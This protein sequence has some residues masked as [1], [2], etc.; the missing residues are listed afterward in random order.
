MSILIELLAV[1]QRMFFH[2]GYPVPSTMAINSGDFKLCGEV[3]IMSVLQGG[4]A[5]NCLAPPVAC[6][7]VG[8]PLSPSEI[9]KSVYKSACENVSMVYTVYT[10]HLKLA[11]NLVLLIYHLNG[12]CSCLM[13]LLCCNVPIFPLSEYQRIH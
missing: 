6:F 7:I 12:L 11:D 4:P 13:M 1:I 2:D 3:M 9:Q 10:E 5:P 8:K